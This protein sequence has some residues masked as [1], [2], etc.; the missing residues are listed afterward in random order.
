MKRLFFLLAILLAV[1]ALTPPA[2]AQNAKD[3][4]K[5]P[6]AA[7]RSTQKRALV[8]G[9]NGYQIAPRLSACGQDARAFAEFLRQ[10]WGFSGEGSVTLVTDAQVPTKSILDRTIKSWVGSLHPGDEVVFFFSGHGVWSD[11]QDFLVPLDGDVDDVR[12]TCVSYNALRLQIESKQPRR[13]LFF[14]DACRNLFE[15]KKAGVRSSEFGKSGEIERLEFAELRS[16]RA[17]QLSHERD[18]GKGSA[19]TFFLLQAL[20]GA[21]EARDENGAVTFAST[22][23]FVLRRTS[24]YVADRFRV[25]QHP[26]GLASYPDMVLAEGAPNPKPP[27][28]ATLTPEQQKLAE[29]LPPLEL[30][31]SELEQNATRREFALLIEKYVRYLPVLRPVDTTDYAALRFSDV[32]DGNDPLFEALLHLRQL[33]VFLGAP[34]GRFRPDDPLTRYEAVT[35]LARVLSILQNDPRLQLKAMPVYW[36]T[37]SPE[38]RRQ[39]EEQRIALAQGQQF[40][41][42]PMNSWAFDAIRKMGTAV[43]LELMPG[44]QFRGQQPLSRYHMK[45]WI[46]NVMSVVVPRAR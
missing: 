1:V 20:R 27:G 23:D 7:A 37:A 21:P 30:K 44:G 3:A 11:G 42:V 9:V 6:V 4:L 5:K 33:E 24:A 16:C 12:A 22:Q 32:K 41:D 19:F 45:F 26:F 38:K 36:E 43:V 31:T 13:A 46:N 10:S 18:D 25:E 29:L 39:I 35:V 40:V 34:D 28:G 15:G 2:T 8:I 17:G 14:T